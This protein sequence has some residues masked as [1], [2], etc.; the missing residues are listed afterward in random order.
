MEHTVI[1]L[2]A[3]AFFGML[4]ANR[5]STLGRSPWG[6]GVIAF[7]ISPLLVWIVLEIAGRKEEETLEKT[8]EETLKEIGD[9]E[10]V[11]D[12]VK[13]IPEN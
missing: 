4:V 9:N 7:L 2:V 13:A 12:I 3:A 1:I 8:L 5:A 11:S 10:K 6:W